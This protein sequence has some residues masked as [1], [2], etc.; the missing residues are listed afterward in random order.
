LSHKDGVVESTWK[1]NLTYIFLVI[2]ILSRREKLLLE[3]TVADTI[4]LMPFL[5]IAVVPFLEFSLPFLL[6]IF[7]NML[8]STYTTS[9]QEKVK[10]NASLKIRLEMAKFLQSATSRMVQDELKGEVTEE[11]ALLFLKRASKGLPVTNTEIIKVGKLLKVRKGCSLQ[12]LAFFTYICSERICLVQYWIGAIASRC[13]LLWRF[14]IRA[15]IIR[16][17]YAGE[18]IEAASRR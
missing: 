8:P 15:Q 9:E 13:A 5:V 6:K 4:R 17:V 3:R 2:Q 16:G 18:K 14:H 11:S 7:P 1:W 10:H 12:I